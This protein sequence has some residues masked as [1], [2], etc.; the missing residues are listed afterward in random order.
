[1]AEAIDR[2]VITRLACPLMQWDAWGDISEGLGAFAADRLGGPLPG[3]VGGVAVLG[4][5]TAVKTAPR[6]FWLLAADRASLPRGLP[7]D[8]GAE[9][10]L[11]E[12]RER[13]DIRTPRLRDVLAQC[14]AVDWDRTPDRATFAPMH[15]VPVMFSRRSAEEGTFLVPRTFAQSIVEWLEDCL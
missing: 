13:I 3:E 9:L 10:D 7:A 1:M 5:V 14:L 12:G 11:G 4:A 6:R 8:L 2:I 15:R